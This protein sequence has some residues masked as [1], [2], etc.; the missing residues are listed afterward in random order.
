MKNAGVISLV[1]IFTLAT[2]LPLLADTIKVDMKP[3][4]WEH[5]IKLV[6]GNS[7]ATAQTQQMQTAME[8]VKK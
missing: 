1:G 7:A 2:A 8:E 5:R 3:G 4:L 6:G